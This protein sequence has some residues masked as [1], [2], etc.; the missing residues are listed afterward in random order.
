[1][2]KKRNTSFQD[3]ESVISTGVEIKG[4]INSKGS[5]R[6]DGKVEGKLDILGDIVLGEKGYINGEI[7]TEN[8]ILA[9]K[10]EGNVYAKNRLEITASGTLY[11]DITCN[12]LIVEEGGILEGKTKMT[13]INEKSEVGKLTDFKK[14]K[15]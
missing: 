14:S 6:I 13:K 11:G 1:M 10:I 15:A 7:K 4:E 5:L 12:T 3:I 9:G 2:R 8:I